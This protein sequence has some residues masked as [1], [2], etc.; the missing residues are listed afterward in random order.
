M[1]MHINMSF[2][3]HELCISAPVINLPLNV[4]D[5]ISRRTVQS[6]SQPTA[7]L[8]CSTS[9]CYMCI[10]LCRETADCRGALFQSPQRTM[11]TVK[12]CAVL[13]RTAS[14]N[15]V[16]VKSLSTYFFQCFSSKPIPEVNVWADFFLISS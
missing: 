4:W 14:P 5:V 7:C 2:S 10:L 12:K 3:K 15:R 8:S 6:T 11:C 16:K 1:S 13:L 9:Y